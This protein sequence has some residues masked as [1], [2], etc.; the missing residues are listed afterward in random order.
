MIS[1]LSRQI[2]KKYGEGADARKACGTLCGVTGILFNLLLFTGKCIAG[3]LSHSIAIT[4]D[5]FNNLSDAASS[6]IT[7]IG[8][9]MAGQK[10]DS[11]HP[12]GH[13]RMEYLA[14]L[15]VSALILVMAFELLFTSVKRLFVPENVLYD[16]LIVGILILSILIKCYMYLYNTRIGKRIASKALHATALDS[17]TDALS[18]A[19]VLG[20]TLLSHFSSLSLDG[21]CGILV[22]LFILRTGFVSA[23]ETLDPLLGQA[24]DPVF[25]KEIE[26]LVLSH[27]QI[28]GIHDLIVHNY[29]P[30]RTMISLHAEVPASGDMLALHEVIDTI[31]R[32]LKEQL[33]CDAVIHMDPVCTDDSEVL[34][35]KEKVTSFLAELDPVL[36]MHDF[37]LVRGAARTCLFFDVMIPYGY[38]LTDEEVCARLT[39][40]IEAEDPNFSALICADKKFA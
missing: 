7:L 24:P 20:T 17:L 27:E 29:G 31:E 1:L 25:V 34:L 12:F 30:G 37:R 32:Q 23:K 18:T 10:P 14:G 28:L 26:S 8:F 2:F 40:R 38:S 21:V 36:T 3:V 4:A 22:G 35:W 33:L 6:L 5:A 19:L 15:A 39:A 11:D 13:G 9:R 16:P